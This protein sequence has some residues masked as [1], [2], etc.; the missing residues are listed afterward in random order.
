MV[1]TLGV[2]YEELLK[3]D[4]DA[5]VLLAWLG[6]TAMLFLVRRWFGAL[7]G[8]L[9]ASLLLLSVYACTEIY[10]RGDL[11]EFAAMMLLPVGLCA[12]AAWIGVEGASAQLVTGL[13][14]IAVGV[15][16]FATA[17][18]LLGIHEM[19]AIATELRHLLPGGGRAAGDEPPEA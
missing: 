12:L 11:T 16:V 7:S 17:S 3:H 9:A 8:A 18:H 2:L 6:Y 4:T 19:R 5:V 10:V 15:V 14:P 1:P 13:V